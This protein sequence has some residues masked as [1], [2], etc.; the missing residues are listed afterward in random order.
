MS[1]VLRHPLIIL[2]IVLACLV[3]PASLLA[4]SAQAPI[5]VVTTLPFLKEF[6]ERI[7][8][9]TVSVSSLTNGMENVY[10]YTPTPGDVA[11]VGRARVL[12]QVGVGMEAWTA[13]MIREANNPRLTIV[14]VGR[15]IPLL[16]EETVSNHNDSG[17]AHVSGN[18][19]VWL[20]PENAK[21]MV[22][23][24]TDT[25]IKLAPARRSTYL[26]NQA[27]YL[28]AIDGVEADIK[29]QVGQLKDRR[30]VTHQA[31]WPYFARRFG[32]QVEGVILEGPGRE[33]SSD[34]TA[35][36]AALIRQ[37]RIKVIVTEPQLD[38][39]AARALAE[40]TGARLVTVAS[41][42]GAL[43]GTDTYLEML[44]YDARQLVEAL[45]RP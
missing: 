22:R 29:K 18:P 44:S 28:K 6:V 13:P 42:P 40:G 32:F 33:R 30:I 43:P 35:S 41:L 38:A 19:H 4:A 45:S 12:V 20:D 7:G 14:T 36:L 37:K 21:M 34:T 39:A 11:A 16:R 3:C 10:T 27:R 31:A 2:Q 9:E 24:I 8:G 26:S 17:E 25:L 1:S 23:T 5:P 15:G